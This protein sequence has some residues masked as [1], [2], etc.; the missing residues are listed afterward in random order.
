MVIRLNGNFSVFVEVREKLTV[1]SSQTKDC[2]LSCSVQL[3]DAALFC[4][5]V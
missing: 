4:P 3:A 1:S 5:N 2:D